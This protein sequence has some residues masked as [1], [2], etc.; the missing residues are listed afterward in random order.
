[1]SAPHPATPL[2]ATTVAG[3][4]N[5]LRARGLRVSGARRLVLEALFA[6]GGPV[7]AEEIAGGRDLGSVYR[8]LDVLEQVG[9]V[10]HVHLGHGPGLYAPADREYALCE[11]CGAVRTFEDGELD[12]VRAAVAA[13][14]GFTAGFSHFPLIGLCPDCQLRTTRNEF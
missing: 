1:M 12:A 14:S 6:A 13:A 2:R 7:T 9:L 10:K 5:A 4:V 11:R 8:N 3:A